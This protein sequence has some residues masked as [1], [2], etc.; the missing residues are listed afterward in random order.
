MALIVFA[1]ALLG[2][3]ER[4]HARRISFAGLAASG[5]A[6]VVAYPLIISFGTTLFASYNSA[7]RYSIPFL[8]AGV[9][10]MFP[11]DHLWY[12]RNKSFRFKLCMSAISLFLG[13]FVL[14]CFSKSLTDRVQQAYYSGSQLAF[15]WLAVR[16]EYINYNEEVLYGDT[17]LRIASAQEQIPSGQAVVVWVT[18]PFYLDYK[19]NI[20][21]DAEEAGLVNSW[22]YIPEVNYFIFEYSGF[23]NRGLIENYLIAQVPSRLGQLCANRLNIFLQSLSEISKNADFLYN[24]GKIVVFKKK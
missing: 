1:F 22:A 4:I 3:R 14:F 18:T 21:F 19:R 10:L 23:A 16:P 11:L 2:Y 20:I 9:P 15:Q 6:I 7:L 5:T 24:D 12:L 13:V 17:R 8:I